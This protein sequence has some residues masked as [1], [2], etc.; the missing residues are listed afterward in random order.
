VA[1]LLLCNLRAILRAVSGFEAARLQTNHTV[2]VEWLSAGSVE[3]LQPGVS[4]GL[5][6]RILHAG[7]NGEVKPVGTG[8]RASRDLVAESVGQDRA[9]RLVPQV[10]PWTKRFGL[11]AAK[12][13]L[14]AVP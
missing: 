14:A 10:P 9:K 3:Q 12:P 13:G 8:S 2:R 11:A 7:S 1:V 4:Y 5:S 6:L